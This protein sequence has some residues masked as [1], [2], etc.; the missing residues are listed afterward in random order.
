MKTIEI[1]KSCLPSEFVSNELINAIKIK[2]TYGGGMGGSVQDLY[3][4]NVEDISDTMKRLKL[5]NGKS[6]LVNTKYIVYITTGMVLKLK[7]DITEHINRKL[8]NKSKNEKII[9][10]EYIKIY[11]E[12]K[13]EI[14]D[15][16]QSRF[17]IKNRIIKCDNIF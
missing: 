9:K 4:T 15:K 16:F 2:I 3:C 12:E 10:T 14:V 8:K 11:D 5:L 1:G 17:D 7:T 6:I 13:Y